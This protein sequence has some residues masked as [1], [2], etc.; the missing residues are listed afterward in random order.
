MGRL[1]WLGDYW[2]VSRINY[3]DPTHTY[4]ILHKKYPDVT[5]APT[6]ILMSPVG[7]IIKAQ[8]FTL[9]PSPFI[10]TPDE[11]VIYSGLYASGNVDVNTVYI[12]SA[13]QLSFG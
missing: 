6:A 8:L 10:F 11:Y 13:D 9:V 5:F 1:F 2:E 12:R 4:V 3:D 7:C